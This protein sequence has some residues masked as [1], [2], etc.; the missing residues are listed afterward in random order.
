MSAAAE[1]RSIEDAARRLR[2]AALE[3]GTAGARGRP[4]RR[5]AHARRSGGNRAAEA[6]AG[7][8]A[9]AGSPASIPGTARS[10]GRCSTSDGSSYGRGWPITGS[11]TWKTRPIEDLANPRNLVRHEVLPALQ[12]VVW[13]VGARGARACRRG[14]P[15]GRGAP[16]RADARSLARAARPPTRETGSVI[17]VAG[18]SARCRWH[19]RRRVLLEA[20]RRAGVREPGFAEVEALG[21]DARGRG[22]TGRRPCRDSVRADRNGRTVVL[23][24]R[25]RA[26]VTPCR[27]SV[28]RCR[29]RAASG[30]RKLAPP[31]EAETWAARA[32]RSPGAR[33]MR[34]LR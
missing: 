25:G 17:D 5:R 16:G 23:S 27:R 20:L 3:R 32:G 14:R 11:R 4:R 31:C 34:R 24:G 22:R 9:R 13:P 30:L 33:P 28:M 18:A 10:S 29:C 8:R 6:A 15:G 21:R 12:R 19:L 1:G 7:R 26:G 2:Y